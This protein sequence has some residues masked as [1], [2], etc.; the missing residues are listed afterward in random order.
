MRLSPSETFLWNLEMS[1]V[2]MT[3]LCMSRV[4]LDAM[5]PWLMAHRLQQM[6]DE[7]RQ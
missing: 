2:L 6:F 1:L 5:N 4:N 7:G 3:I